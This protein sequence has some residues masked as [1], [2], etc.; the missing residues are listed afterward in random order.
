M[1]KADTMKP[2]PQKVLFKPF[3]RD[4]HLNVEAVSTLPDAFSPSRR[5]GRKE[6]VSGGLANT[7]RNW[8]LSAATEESQRIRQDQT[9]IEVTS[10]FMDRSGRAIEIIDASGKHWLLVGE[11]SRGQA[12]TAVSLRRIRER[13]TVHVRGTHTMWKLPLMQQSHEREVFVAA[14]WDVG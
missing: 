12:T 1:A 10:A 2:P 8:V 7:V 6:Y 3:A 9:M 5:K 4:S 13:G 14:Q 11:P